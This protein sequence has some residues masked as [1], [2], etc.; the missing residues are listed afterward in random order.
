MY[1]PLF[2]LAAAAGFATSLFFVV[3]TAAADPYKW[4]ALY[5]AYVAMNCGFVTIEQCR[6]TISGAGGSC[7]PN[8]FTADLIKSL[9]SAYESIVR[10]SCSPD[11]LESLRQIDVKHPAGIAHILA[12]LAFCDLVSQIW[13]RNVGT[14]LLD[15]IFLPVLPPAI[16]TAA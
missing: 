6:A 14:K 2:S 13:E 1:K 8:Q 15:K 9:L 11:G 10:A 12:P 16:A 3:G 4:C 5:S 7:V